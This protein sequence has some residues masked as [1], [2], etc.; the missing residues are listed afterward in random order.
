MYIS[1]LSDRVLL[2]HM[3]SN[4]YPKVKMEWVPGAP[5]ERTKSAYPNEKYTRDFALSL[6]KKNA[7]EKNDLVAIALLER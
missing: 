2:D 3:R 1:I 7:V 5:F 4:Q 6:L